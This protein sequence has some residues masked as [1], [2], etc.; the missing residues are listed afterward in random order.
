[1]TCVTIPSILHFLNFISF[2]FFFNPLV[3]EIL[4]LC[5][6]TCIIYLPSGFVFCFCF[7]FFLMKQGLMQLILEYGKQ[8]EKRQV[9]IERYFWK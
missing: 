1:M 6:T 9:G 8:V 7:C 2:S 3:P 4:V 5:L